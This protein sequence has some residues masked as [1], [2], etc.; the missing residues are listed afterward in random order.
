[1]LDNANASFG[2]DQLRWFENEIKSSKKHCFVFT[3]D[4]FFVERSPPD[5]EHIT[6]IKERALLMSLL[7]NRCDIMFM[8]HLHKRIVK[9]YS[10]V[11]YIMIEN[12]GGNKTICR[13]SVSNNGVSYMF[14]SL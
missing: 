1:V 14:E 8:G 4:N 11:K 3:H 7:K 6:D 2:Y 5:F 9:E 10:G 13:V 12:Y